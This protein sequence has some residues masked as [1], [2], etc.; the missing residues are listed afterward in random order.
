[1]KLATK[2]MQI[3]IQVEKT[4]LGNP[5]TNDAE[6]EQDIPLPPWY[7]APSNFVKDAI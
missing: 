6:N 3:L 7:F 4:W 2:Q 5:A 1:M